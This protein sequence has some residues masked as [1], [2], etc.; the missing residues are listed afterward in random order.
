ADFYTNNFELRRGRGPQGVVQL[1]SGEPV[2]GASVVLVET[3]ESAYLDRSGQFR[4]GRSYPEVVRSGPDGRFE[5]AAKLEPDT[6]PV[7]HEKGYAEVKVSALA[8]NERV[9][10]QPWGRVTGVLRVGPK[11]EPDH[12]V[13]LGSWYYMYEEGERQ[14]P[15]VSVQLST[16][17]DD[18][19]RFTFDRVPPGER[20][21]EL[22]YKIDGRRYYGG[23]PRSHGVPVDVKPGQTTEVRLGGTGRSIVGRVRVVG[24]PQ[25]AVDW[26]RDTHS[27]S[28]ITPSL[29]LPSPSFAGNVSEQERQRAFQEYERRRRKLYQSEEGRELDRR[30]RTYALLFDTNGTF[31]AH[32]IP[33][34]HYALN[35]TVSDPGES[36]GSYRQMGYLHTSFEVPEDRGADPLQPVDVGTFDLRVTATLRIGQMAPGFEAKTFDGRTLRLSDFRGKPVLLE[37]WATWSGS[38]SIDL[39]ALRGA[40]D[41]YAK[42]GRSVIIGL[43]L[44]HDR[45]EAETFLQANAADWPQ[46]YIGPWNESPIR[47]SFGVEGI[48]AA[49]LIDAEGRVARKNLSGAAVRN[50]LRDLLAA[51]SRTNAP[52]RR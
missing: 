49:V 13:V 44:D 30:R 31:R 11:V 12:R 4:S 29:S 5:F 35:M 42:D 45:K 37:F 17:P 20:K 51:A 14:G 33:P 15:P 39:T 21:V 18:E 34:G 27:I 19:G 46:C 22:E 9:V 26:Q 10:L 16:T 6:I 28:L 50:A 47:D 36:D 8:T 48:P 3:T 41:A 52:P 40:Y 1:P 2:A 32:H 43:N 25:D 24:A 23:S 38:R 7:S